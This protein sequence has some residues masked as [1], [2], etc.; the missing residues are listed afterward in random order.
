MKLKLPDLWYMH[1]VFH[2]K[3]LE[4]YRQYYGDL[5]SNLWKVLE[6]IED[7]LFAVYEVKEIRDSF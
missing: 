3:L 2:V 5:A 7:L 1:P 4:P 6:D